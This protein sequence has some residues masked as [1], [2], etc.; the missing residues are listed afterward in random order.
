[1]ADMILNSEDNL[2]NL[3]Q[4]AQKASK[5]DQD[6]D[7]RKY[8]RQVTGPFGDH[9]Y[10]IDQQGRNLRRRR[11]K[12]FTTEEP[13]CLANMARFGSAG[14]CYKKL[15]YLDKRAWDLRLKKH[16]L[17]ASAFLT[18]QIYRAQNEDQSSFNLIR[19]VKPE[20]IT[21]NRAEV[22]FS[23]DTPGNFQV[24]LWTSPS[25]EWQENY[26]AQFSLAGVEANTDEEKNLTETFYRYRLTLNGLTNSTTYRFQLLQ[27]LETIITLSDEPTEESGESE[28]SAES[29]ESGELLLTEAEYSYIQGET[30]Y[31]QFTTPKTLSFT[32]YLETITD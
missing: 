9:E 22:T 10:Y 26:P 15:S 30:G 17:H 3:L 12:S 29:T 14:S 28:K 6:F 13:G 23:C 21:P 24:N 32:Y 18:R 4:E 2:D 16:R 7:L 27:P 31:Y 1:M 19:Q 5:T 20:I 25:N 11:R 8:C